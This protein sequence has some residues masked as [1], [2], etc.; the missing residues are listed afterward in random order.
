MP[1]FDPSVPPPMKN[2]S[3]NDGVKDVSGKPLD[4]STPKSK[5]P[6][7]EDE[8]IPK[9]KRKSRWDF[10]EGHKKCTT[11]VAVSC[12]VKKIVRSELHDSRSCYKNKNERKFF[13]R[14]ESLDQF[15]SRSR[16]I[17]EHV[18]VFD[19]KL[20]F[21]GNRSGHKRNEVDSYR[22]GATVDKN[23]EF[24]GHKDD[25]YQRKEVYS[26]R[27]GAAVDRNLEFQGHRSDHDQR[28][29][30]DSRKLGAA[31]DRDWDFEFQGNRSVYGQ[32]DETDFCRHGAAVGKSM[33]FQGNI[34]GHDHR[35]ETD[36]RGYDDLHGS[37]SDYRPSERFYRNACG[38]DSKMEKNYVGARRKI[39][40]KP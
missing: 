8:V 23:L 24:Q 18:E 3:G 31:V 11:P 16:E 10:N 17:S 6:E 12:E 25:H 22:H 1:V 20:E 5:V 35:N 36:S 14:D 26:R 27:H 30:T 19:R 29:N 40:Y 37:K 9:I 4:L 34:S 32:R 7:V 38:E 15:R 21:Q 33:K 2:I 28:C 13:D 39:Y